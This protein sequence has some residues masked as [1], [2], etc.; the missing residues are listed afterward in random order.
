[1]QE[2]SVIPDDAPT[3]MLATER[4]VESERFITPEEAAAFL[5]CSPVTVKRLAR[6][7]KLPGHWLTNGIRKRWRFLIS[8]LASSMKSEVSS[9]RSSAPLSQKKG[10]AV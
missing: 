5:R 8:E 6:Q 4:S 10:K 7:G 2:V 3:Q 9:E 1:V